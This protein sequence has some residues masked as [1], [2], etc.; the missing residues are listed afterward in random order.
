MH[1]HGLPHFKCPTDQGYVL[2]AKQRCPDCS[3][4]SVT[5]RLHA[6]VLRQAHAMPCQISYLASPGAVAVALWPAAQ[7]SSYPVH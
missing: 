1:Q 6:R 4:T 5:P 3:S 2:F 7:L